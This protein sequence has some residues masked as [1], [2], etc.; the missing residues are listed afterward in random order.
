MET[1]HDYDY[2]YQE[3]VP[4][5]GKYL[6]LRVDWAFKYVFSK[7]EILLDNK[8]LTNAYFYLRMSGGKDAKV[9]IGYAE[10]LYIPDGSGPAYN[11]TP[12]QLAELPEEYLSY[13][14]SPKVKGKG[15]RNETNQIQ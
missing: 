2:D 12:E 9:K 1:L 14:L 6:D 8:V 7:K 5:V 3:D 13:V 4:V 15:N 10:A 11:L